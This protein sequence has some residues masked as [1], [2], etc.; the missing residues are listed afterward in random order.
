[1]T[2]DFAI[3][4]TTTGLFYFIVLSLLE[5]VLGIDNIIFISIITEP[6]EA[7][8]RRKARNIGL[9]LALV[10]RLILLT[11][12]GWIMRLTEPFTTIF[13]WEMTGQKLVL[14]IGGL[15]LI[16]K[17]TMEMHDSM[18]HKHADPDASK[19]KKSLKA[20]IVQI[21][22]VDIVFSFDSII[23]AIGMTNGMAKET[24]HSPMIIIY[25]AVIVSMIVMM[26]FAKPI[27][28][29]IINRPTVKMIALAFL[30]TIGV[31]LVAEAFDQHVPK[32]YIYFAMVYSLTVEMINLRMNKNKEKNLDFNE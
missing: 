11:I 7:T 8:E 13:G 4:L 23:T 5:I 32:G 25:L 20:I 19:K 16:Y 10:I 2:L 29:F 22:L 24:H 26:I 14:L 1:M 15:F 30:V 31:V 17:S 6:L 18:T 3:M 28:E 9:S 21:L 27:S 12:V